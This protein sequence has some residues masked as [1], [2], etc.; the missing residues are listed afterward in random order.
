LGAKLPLSG[1]GAIFVTLWKDKE[2]GLAVKTKQGQLWWL[3]MVKYIL[4]QYFNPIILWLWVGAKQSHTIRHT[5][6]AIAVR[7]K[8]FSSSLSLSRGSLVT[9]VTWTVLSSPLPVSFGSYTIGKMHCF[10]LL[11]LFTRSVLFSRSVNL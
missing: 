3:S 2:C 4:G 11:Q 9:V 10:T 5:L 6:I 8:V 7:L 1:H